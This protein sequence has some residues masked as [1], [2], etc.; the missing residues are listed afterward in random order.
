MRR[1]RWF[2]TARLLFLDG[3]TIAPG[4]MSLVTALLVVGSVASTC[5]PLGYRLLVDGALEQ[6]YG[7][8][9]GGALLVGGLM[10]LGWLLNSVGATEAMALSDRISL[11]R[12]AELIV[13]VGSV[14]G[15][16]HLERPQYLREVEAVVAGRRQLSGAPRQILTSVASA[17]RI[18][19]LLV[20]LATVSPWLLLLPVC[21]VPPLLADRIGRR[22]ARRSDDAMADDK[23]LAG[24]YFQL[25]SSAGAA[26]E[27]RSYGLGAHLTAEHQRLAR[28]VQRRSRRE[29]LLVLGVTGTGWLLYA[30]ALMGA[31]AFVVIDAARG[32]TSLGT[33]L[34]AVSLIRRSRTQLASVS[35]RAGALSGVSTL[36]RRWLWLEDHAAGEQAR[37]GDLGAP[38]RLRTGIR[39]AGVGF[40]Y[41]GTDRDVLSGV[42][43]LLPAGATVALVGENGSGKTTLIKLLLAMYRPTSGAITIDGTDLA[44][45]DPRAWRDRSA[46]AFQDFS[47]LHL[48]VVEG[49]GVAELHRLTDHPAA[50]SALVRAGAADLA[51]SL[52]QGLD[53]V[54]GSPA[55]G[56]MGLSGGQWQKIALGRAM[57]RADP[58]LLVLD[59]PTAS[60][61][62]HAENEL[63][64]RYVEAAAAAA[65]RS[66]TVTVRVSH[67]FSTVRAAEKI[68]FVADGAIVESGS[69]DELIA[70]GGRYAELFELQAAG[71]R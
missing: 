27:V 71:F 2:R 5:Y 40:K 1:A 9:I 49:V 32:A 38:D 17:A 52:P 55:T 13:L 62:A 69:H 16:E 53:T 23:R 12:T 60:L 68:L 39:L 4:W 54:V 35:G 43:V 44:A 24:L 28:S 45:V 66:G 61:D 33:A 8:M 41:P 50:A 58:L 19:A 48:P 29:A 18:V 51:E 42:D 3:F 11:Q 31:I 7:A 15:V 63:F 22:I 20:L 47:R 10:S 14:P 57:R 34:M 67:R 46:A 26:A 36:A 64:S 70:A 25:A 65:Q 59:E 30:A 6:R 56:G 37:S 21:T